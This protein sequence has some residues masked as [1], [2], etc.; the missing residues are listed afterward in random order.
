MET[1]FFRKSV[2]NVYIMQTE[3]VLNYA[4][5]LK[6]DINTIMVQIKCKFEMET[7]ILFDFIFNYILGL[8]HRLVH[9]LREMAT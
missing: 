1:N 3:Q 4:L 6:Q 8:E 9:V 5:T 2:Y 7:S